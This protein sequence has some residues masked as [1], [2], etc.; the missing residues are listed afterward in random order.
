M[1]RK[2]C[3]KRTRPKPKA[4]LRLPDLDKAKS[5]VLNSL[6][7]RS[8]LKRTSCTSKAASSGTNVINKDSQ[9]PSSIFSRRSTQTPVTPWPMQ[10]WP[11]ATYCWDGTATCHPS[12]HSQGPKRRRMPLCSSIPISPKPTPLWRPSCGFMIGNGTR[13]RR[14]LSTAWSWVPTIPPRAT[15]TPSTR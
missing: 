4:V 15:G 14:N 12:R 13:L 6:T 1:P 9:R 2:P 7:I 10:V 11:I 8:I 5:A 3:S